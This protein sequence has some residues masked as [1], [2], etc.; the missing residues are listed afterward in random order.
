MQ[1]QLILKAQFGRIKN[2]LPGLKYPQVLR[3]APW[4]MAWTRLTV[5]AGNGGR[6]LIAIKPSMRLGDWHG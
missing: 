5:L 6:I 1:Y 4:L 2:R 3:D